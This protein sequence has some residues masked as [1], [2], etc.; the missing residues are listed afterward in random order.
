MAVASGRLVCCAASVSPTRAKLMAVA[1]SA[2]T[3]RH[4][5]ATTVT[6]TVE[7]DR[8]LTKHVIVAAVSEGTT[9]GP[10]GPRSSRCP[11]RFAR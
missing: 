1:T 10:T 7:T 8:P 11:A 5:A 6:T 3:R 2:A 9:R 4:V